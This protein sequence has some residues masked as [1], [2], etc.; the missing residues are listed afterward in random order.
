MPVLDGI[1]TTRELV[2]AGRPA[3]VLILTLALATALVVSEA[4][5][6]THVSDVPARLA[7]RD[8]VPAVIAAYE[9]GLVAI[10]DAPT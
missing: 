10:G 9:T 4:T 6:K 2:A 5:V 1:A 8:R 7:P 3:R